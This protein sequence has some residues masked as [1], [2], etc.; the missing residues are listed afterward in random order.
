MD[1][2]TDDHEREEAVRKWWHEYWKPLT[3]G[4]VIALGGLLGWRQFQAY[5][6]E[7]HQQEAYA[8]FQVQMQ[9]QQQGVNAVPQ[10]EAYMQEHQDIFGA[11][12]AL[13]T[14]AVQ[15]LAHDYEGALESVEFAKQHGGEL[16]APSAS[17][18]E[19]RLY[20]QTGKPAEAERVL[21]SIKDGAYAPEAA[22][23]RG[24]IALAAGDR[25][26]AKKNYQEAIDLLIA[27]KVQ[28]S[29][30]LQMKF[31][32]VIA[33]GDTPAFKQAAAAVDALTS[34]GE[35]SAQQ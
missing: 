29:P 34:T 27:R 7:Q 18:T 10:A 4:V 22:E 23:V 24:D 21:N 9:L 30:V 1:V 28:V 20:A 13:D 11:V 17:L 33:A 19:A 2:L 35:N 12:L 15:I 6:L 14:A 5:Q 16:I 26:G 25:A 8:V 3:L 31:D 32:N